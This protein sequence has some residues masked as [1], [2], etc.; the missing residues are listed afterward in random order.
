MKKGAE[1]ERRKEGREEEKKEDKNVE[2]SGWKDGEKK[3]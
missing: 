1:K 3:E 2:G